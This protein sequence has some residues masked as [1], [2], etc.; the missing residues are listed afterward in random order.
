L[1]VQGVNEQRAWWD[2]DPQSLRDGPEL[3]DGIPASFAATLFAITEEDDEDPAPH[4]DAE[5]ATGIFVDQ[6][7]DMVRLIHP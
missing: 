3:E 2:V 7:D 1:P 5:H 4:P 6:A